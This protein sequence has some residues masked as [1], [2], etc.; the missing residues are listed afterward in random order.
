MDSNLTS[1][2]GKNETLEELNHRYAE[3]LIPVT[4]FLGF[5]AVTGVI[6]N[7]L[8]LFVFWR[9]KEYRKDTF[10]IFVISHGVIDLVECVSLIPVEIFKHQQYFAFENTAACKAKCFFNVFASSAAS[11]MLILINID[12]F[13]RICQPFKNQ[14]GYGLA[15]KLSSGMCFISILLA[16]PSVALCGIQE[17]L[18]MNIQGGL[19]KVYI[20]SYEE[21]YKNNGWREAYKI[22]LLTLTFIMLVLCTI[23]YILI[24]REVVMSFRR[25][26]ITH[27]MRQNSAWPDVSPSEPFVQSD[28]CD[29][30]E[31]VTEVSFK[32][33]SK[34]SSDV[35][36][37]DCLSIPAANV[38]LD[39]RITHVSKRSL[40]NYPI[41]SYRKTLIWFILTVIF[42]VT[43]IL[44]SVLALKRDAIFTMRPNEFA[45]YSFFFRIYFVNSMAN[46]IVYACLFKRFRNVCRAY[47][48][49]SVNYIFTSLYRKSNE[50]RTGSMNVVFH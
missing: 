22:A 12:R 10:R 14:V 47:F 36:K 41:S 37:L 43:H 1:Q 8:V 39:S 42:V 17:N 25:N 46:P 13:R 49:T 24:G 6:G 16:L 26:C 45:V 15:I 48:I 34:Q 4:I 18:M 19:T 5:L 3:A 20:C 40:S 11:F 31:K 23:V 27:F 9:S 50:T 29:K 2:H 44:Y 33:E 30:R 32:N 28:G 38:T 35:M 7:I 21:I